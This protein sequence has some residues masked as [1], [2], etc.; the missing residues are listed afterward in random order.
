MVL[1]Q[2]LFLFFG[3]SDVCVEFS[4][5]VEVAACAV[6][7]AP[8]NQTIRNQSRPEVSVARI[9]SPNLC[10]IFRAASEIIWA[11]SAN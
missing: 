7:L 4:E 9:H 6:P 11:I 3:V 1:Q 2:Y 8:I 5:W 10:A